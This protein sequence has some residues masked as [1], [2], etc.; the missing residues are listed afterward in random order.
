MNK[1]LV[2]DADTKLVSVV[3]FDSQQSAV[4]LPCSL[5]N[6]AASVGDDSRV[7]SF[8]DLVSAEP[9][10]SCALHIEQA[11]VQHDSTETCE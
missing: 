3:G 6:H 9:H 7:C 11:P 10:I 4:V 5:A 8:L 2:W 1:A